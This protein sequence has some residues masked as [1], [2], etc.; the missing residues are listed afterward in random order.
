[1]IYFTSFNPLPGYIR[2]KEKWKNQAKKSQRYETDLKRSSTRKT[3]TT[4][5]ITVI[6]PTFGLKL[7]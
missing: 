3:L 1:M 2:E 4:F 7:F 6:T 5:L